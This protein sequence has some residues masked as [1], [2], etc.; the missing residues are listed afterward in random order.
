MYFCELKR[1]NVKEIFFS[2]KK[3]YDLVLMLFIFVVHLRFDIKN[4]EQ[5]KI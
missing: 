3:C 2:H 4:N 5:L 1:K